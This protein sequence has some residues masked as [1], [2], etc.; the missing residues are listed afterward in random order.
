MYKFYNTIGY[1]VTD[2]VRKSITSLWQ[3]ARNPNL[4]KWFMRI[5]L[6][7]LI[8]FVAFLQVTLAANAQKISLSKKNASLTEIFKELRKQS[9]YDFL[10]NKDQ[11]KISKPVTIQANENELTDVLNKC[12][13]GQPFT[14]KIEDKTII[15]IN[16]RQEQTKADV[17]PIE[18]KGRIIDENGNA[19][20]GASV[21]VKGTERRIATNANGEFA[22]SNLQDNAILVI[23]YVGYELREIGAKANLGDIKLVM[24][25]GKLDEVSIVSTGYQTL[26]KERATGSFVQIDNQLLNRRTGTNILDRLDGIASGVIF[27]KISGPVGIAPP[28][29]KLGISI[30]GRA[31]IDNNVSADPLVILDNF[32]YEGDLS[33]INPNDVESI[34]LLK[35]AAAA[36]IWGARSGNGVIVITT[37]KGRNNEAL[38]IDFNSNVT[39][40]DKPNLKYSRNFLNSSDYI[41]LEKL[42]FDLKYY[43]A[44]L[45][46]TTTYPLI[47]SAVNIFASQR[48]GTISDTQA[49]QQLNELKNNDIRDQ[50]SRYFY[51]RSIQQQ[52]ALSIRGGTEKNSQYVSIGYD[53]N[54]SNN[55]GGEFGRLTLN[56]SNTYKPVKGFEISTSI[57]LNRSITENPYTLIASLSPYSQIVDA[58]N[59]PLAVPFGF[60]EKY[61]ALAESQ[62]FLNW[63][64]RPLQERDEMDNVTKTNNLLLRTSAKYNIISGLSA[65]IYYQ[66]QTESS[67]NR[68]YSS[69]DRYYVRNLINSYAQRS[70]SGIF[71]YPMPIGGVLFQNEN[72]LSAHNLRTQLNFNKTIN[73]NHQISGIAGAEIKESVSS[74]SNNTF[75]GYNEEF[76]TAVNNLNYTTFYTINPSGTGSRT[77]P[78]PTD[79][80]GG[81]TNR[82]ISYY[83]NGAY[84]YKSKYIFNIS[85]RKDGANIFGAKTN[86]KI[87]PLWSAGFGYEI[88]KESFYKVGWMP[89]LKIRATY[90]YN[91]NV[92]NTSS[93]LTASY[94]T[95]GLTGARIATVTRAP[96]PELRWEKV[97][98]KNFGIDFA[99]KNNR[100]SGSFE[101]YRKVGSDLIDNAPLAL[102]TGFMSFKGNVASVQ[103]KG[104]DIVLNTINTKGAVIWRSNILYS[105]NK[106][107]VVN[108]NTKYTLAQLA[109]VEGSDE[110]QRYGL[111]L[112]EGNSMF[113]VYSYRFAG[114]DPT[115]GDPLGFLNGV[116]SKDYTGILNTNNLNDIVY[117]GSARP[118]NYGSFRNSISYGGFTV[119]ANCTFKFNYFI[120][121]KSTNLNYTSAVS[122]QGNADYVDRWQNPGDEL[123]S[124]V[125]SLVYAIN[126]NRNTFYQ[127]SSVLVEKGDHIRLQDINISFDFNKKQLSKLPF[128]GI[129][130]YSYI[131][132]IGIL[133][134][135]NKSGIDPDVSSFS[136]YGNIPNPTTYAFGVR[137]NFK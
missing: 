41:D 17:L 5:N 44:D 9:G 130:V 94:S 64:L 91:G 38:K 34:T 68:N 42:L 127:S 12:F 128:T 80:V 103:T 108:F 67:K 63:H 88:S 92:F 31:T 115:N 45:A 89:Y 40:G 39:I 58:N 125:P 14:Y 10:I 82:F 134:R 8:L 59:N 84:T 81:A 35:D 122:L 76:G 101:L 111:F 105:Y 126:A 90:G 43:D 69:P 78:V 57:I 119:S 96:N 110:L 114:I 49:T 97:Q 19:L 11:I 54:R 16:K 65:E 53:H 21:V 20:V 1:G 83:A 25:T 2:H 98:N 32:P 118:I 23:S 87:T 113:G 62:G 48:A 30:R 71:T 47:S 66:Y 104:I 136:T 24:A 129:Q 46:N 7:C 52:Y 137:A 13:E 4:R 123:K 61:L 26:P 50:A 120:R 124:N 116:T 100:I 37:K 51:Q 107:K 79:F 102:N 133:W 3:I 109:N 27:N 86:D 121:R 74:T 15:V 99:S 117:H 132:N 60:S 33:N 93:Y 55:I 106:D 70:S 75:Y 36:S 22:F 73:E 6:T 95:D 18:V 112:K 72:E 56:A 131:N 135:E 28:N 77:L 85:G 29:E